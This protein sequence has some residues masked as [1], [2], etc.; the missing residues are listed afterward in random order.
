MRQSM[1]RKGSCWDNAV[2]ESFFGTLEQEL[3]P[4]TPWQDLRAARKAVSQY[5]HRYYNA[6]RR[7]SHNGQKSPTAT[8]AQYRAALEAAA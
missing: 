2:A 5:I 8:E 7:H 6:N 1:S 3:V 4:E